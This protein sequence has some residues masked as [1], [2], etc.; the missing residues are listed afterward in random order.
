[1]LA[2]G[3]GRERP[4]E[5]GLAE[6]EPADDGAGALAPRIAAAVLEAGL[7]LRVA[8]ER[9]GAVVAGGHRRLQPAPLLLERDGAGGAAEDVLAQRELPL[10]RRPLVGQR[11]AR[12]L[13]P[14]ELAALQLGL[15]G[16]RA[17]QRRL[18][19]AVRSGQREPVA[20]L[21]LE[22]DAVEQRLAGQL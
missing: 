8:P 5:V 19:R 7:R 16:E 9:R 3:E 15:A 21:E 22:R 12:T 14:G 17:Q 4:V 11:D 13:L 6:A 10:E 18:A 2:A 1:Q 20:A